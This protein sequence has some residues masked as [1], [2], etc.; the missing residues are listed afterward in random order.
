M[1]LF[2]RPFEIKCST[3]FADEHPAVFAKVIEGRLLEV[4]IFLSG[5]GI[6]SPVRKEYHFILPLGGRRRG[7]TTGQKQNTG[8]EYKHDGFLHGLIFDVWFRPNDQSS[9]S[10]GLQRKTIRGFSMNRERWPALAAA[11]C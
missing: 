7:V 6:S 2:D 4:S 1:D 11:I 9:A 10:R 8:R 3:V 5:C